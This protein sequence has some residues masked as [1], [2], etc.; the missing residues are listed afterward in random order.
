MELL[1]DLKEIRKFLVDFYNVTECRVALFDLEFN[2]IQSYPTRLST[3]CSIL[4]N[5]TNLNQLC[6]NCDY[7][8]FELCKATKKIMIYEC[9]AGLTEIIIPIL[10]KTNTIMA[11]IMC[12]QTFQTT[13]SF[14]TWDKI[15]AYLKNY[16]LDFE[17]LK[18]SY[19]AQNK[20]TALKIN[21]TANILSL[22]ATYL[23]QSDKIK[24]NTDGLAFKID[25]YILENIKGDLDVETICD[26]F[27]FHKT[28][29]YE[30]TKDIYGVG[31][32]KHIRQ[33]RVQIAKKLLS[34]TKLRISEISEE[35]GI[36]DYNYFT[37]IFKEE[38]FCTPRDFRKNNFLA[39]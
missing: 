36:Y 11:Y 29:F 1:Y 8:S 25:Q 6:R 32:A 3:F 13:S 38:A 33:V 5:E 2:E 37:K 15:Y 18:Q 34:T 22:S 39:R 20:T 19:T 23:Y 14:N 35:V 17:N 26:E 10:S 31:I 7:N 16:N 27:N 9:H 12:G 28:K 4:R 21:S 30:V 24:P